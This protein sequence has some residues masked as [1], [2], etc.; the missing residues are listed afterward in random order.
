MKKAKLEFIA[1]ITTEDG[2]AIECKEEQ[3][4]PEDMDICSLDGFLQT[5]NEY[6]QSVL[7]ARNKICNQITQVWLDDQAKKKRAKK[8][9]K[10][11]N[12]V[13]TAK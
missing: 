9:L 11:G 12:V 8:R 6:E 2:R 7:K 3:S 13:S 1:C 10:A 5:F 4:I